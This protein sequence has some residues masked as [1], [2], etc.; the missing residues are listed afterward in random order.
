MN[1]RILLICFICFSLVGCSRSNKV[2]DKE[3]PTEEVIEE[4]EIDGVKK[5]EVILTKD[6]LSKLR[7][8]LEKNTSI[9][10]REELRSGI[11]DELVDNIYTV[12][13]YDI[14]A[15]TKN[16]ITYIAISNKIDSNNL[17]SYSGLYYN[18]A[19]ISDLKKNVYYSSDEVDIWKQDTYKTKVL[20]WNLLK[21]KNVYDIYLYLLDDF[22]IG[23]NDKGIKDGNYEIYTK[24]IDANDTMLQNVA[25]DSLD[26]CI[27]T[28]KIKDNLPVSVE[29]KVV[30]NKNNEK[31][32]KA[33]KIYFN[34][35]DTDKLTLKKLGIKE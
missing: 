2:L 11:Y 28:L 29:S 10:F 26:K 34:S 1:K 24:T 33:V 23:E 6:K 7:K 19:Y 30:F 25:Y 18:K 20:D 8:N 15:D 13:Y 9:E 21:Y 16:K 14:K 31:Y 12:Q 3:I 4:S 27:L 35:I 5:E 17:S 32:Y 22:K